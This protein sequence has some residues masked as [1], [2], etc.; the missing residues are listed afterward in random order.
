MRTKTA[1]KK[2]SERLQLLV[3]VSRA[4]V[5]DGGF[6]FPGI[7]GSSNDLI[8]Y[9]FISSFVLE[10]GHGRNISVVQGHL[11]HCSLALLYT[12]T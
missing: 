5:N 6:R 10:H 8:F 1:Q 2:A 3:A 11:L 7:G 4:R 9:F 12:A